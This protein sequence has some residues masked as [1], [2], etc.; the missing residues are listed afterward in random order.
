M[1][2]ED[3][4]IAEA[5]V[6]D[7]A[8]RF[9]ESDLGKIVLGIADQESEAARVALESVD[10]DDIQA[11]RKLQNKAAM[12]RLFRQWLI[13]LFTTGESALEVYRH[14]KKVE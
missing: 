1:S 12:G 3:E 10:A 14:G 11:I 6:G 8:K 2:E 9:L 13:E 4:L 7:E 5:L